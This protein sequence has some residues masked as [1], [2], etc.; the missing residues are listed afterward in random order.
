MM[1]KP[2]RDY[3]AVAIRVKKDFSRAIHALDKFA[4]RP[5]LWRVLR[6]DVDG[7]VSALR[8]VRGTPRPENHL[9]AARKLI[10]KAHHAP[11]FVVK[12]QLPSRFTVAQKG[13]HIEGCLVHDRLRF[14]EEYRSAYMGHFAAGK[15]MRMSQ[16]AP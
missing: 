15:Q 6:A 1:L 5:G 10:E 8:E 11:P 4:Q 14:F 7:W 3:L 2:L 16:K 13:Y 12:S 9:E